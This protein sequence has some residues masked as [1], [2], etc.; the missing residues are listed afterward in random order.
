MRLWEQVAAETGLHV[1]PPKDRANPTFAVVEVNGWPDVARQCCRDHSP[2][3]VSGKVVL[4]GEVL[5]S[6]LSWD[7]AYDQ[8]LT[9]RNVRKVMGS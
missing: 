5:M 6:G 4:R 8:A 7:D 3:D 1:E 2:S 9:L